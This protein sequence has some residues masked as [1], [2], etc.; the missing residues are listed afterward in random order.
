MFRGWKDKGQR[1]NKK[2]QRTHGHRQQ[3]GDFWG[4]GYNGDEW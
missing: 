2:G 3:G 1:T 4:E